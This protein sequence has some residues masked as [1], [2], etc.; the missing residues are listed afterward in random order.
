MTDRSL[1]HEGAAGLLAVACCVLFFLPR[2]AF[3]AG[4]RFFPLGWLAAFVV[5]AEGWWAALVCASLSAAFSIQAL[6]AREGDKA[7]CI[8]ALAAALTVCFLIVGSAVYLFTSLFG[9]RALERC[10]EFLFQPLQE[11]VVGASPV[12]G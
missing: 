3:A 2:L 6:S 5:W 4:W 12:I 7:R 10:L 1:S 8:F 11:W 9:P